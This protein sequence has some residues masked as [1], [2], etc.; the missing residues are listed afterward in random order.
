MT[1]PLR[2]CRWRGA[3]VVLAS[4]AAISLTAVTGG[5]VPALA[6][7]VTETTAPTIVETVPSTVVT[8]APVTVETPTNTVP[9]VASP[10]VTEPAPVTTPS[11]PVSTP[12]APVSTPS[13]PAQPGRSTPSAPVSTLSSAVTTP[14]AP[15]STPSSAVTTPS[16]S[17]TPGSS[18]A[19]TG[20]STP[21]S[22]PAGSTPSSS[23]A[24]STPSSTPSSA[25]TS[26]TSPESSPPESSPA[27]SETTGS[28]SPTPSSGSVVPTSSAT[29]QASEVT[30]TETPQQLVATPENIDLA[31]AAKPVEQIPDAAP[32]TEIDKIRD[33]LVSQ[34]PIVTAP[35]TVAPDNPAVATAS[36]VKQFQPDWVQ[37]DQ[38][39]RPV[40]L[41]PFPD[42]LQIVYQYAGAPR[43]LIIPPLASLV[44]EVAQL[45]AY[46]FTAMVLNAVGVPTN[47]AVGNLFGGGYLPAPGQ[48]PPSPPPVTKLQ[49][50][51]GPGQ[52]HEC[53]LSAVRG[54]AGRRCRSR[55]E[56]RSAQ[57]AARRRDAGVGG[58]DAER[59]RRTTVRDQQDPAVPGHGRAGGR[60]ATG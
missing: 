17:A 19:P 29:V 14:S 11:A 9:T 31:K 35:P 41:N 21:S 44:T 3:V 16:A 20:S 7:P 5:I 47:V 36:A 51:P 38:F 1:A 57:S 50:R 45:G 15:V 34:N 8:Q 2:I 55:P 32:Q 22:S 58:M 28:V 39:Y 48:P 26:P 24:G 6:D 52:V 30:P 18:E 10:T 43:V 42:P 60:T 13:A 12:S 27:V 46:S 4:G 23:P 59:E 53:D 25:E 49:Q 37:Y 40:I 56:G 54:Q 33:Q